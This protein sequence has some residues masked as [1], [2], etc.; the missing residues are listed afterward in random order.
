MCFSQEKLKNKLHVYHVYRLKIIYKH[1]DSFGFYD[2][3]VMVRACFTHVARRRRANIKTTLV[4]C[5]VFAGRR[6]D[7][8]MNNTFKNCPKYFNFNI[9]FT[10]SVSKRNWACGKIYEVAVMNYLFMYIT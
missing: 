4:Q 2:C 7:I 5:L 3:G 6:R 8:L 9:Y 10:C 1:H